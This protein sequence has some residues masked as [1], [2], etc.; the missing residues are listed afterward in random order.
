MLSSELNFV[1]KFHEVDAL[2]I[3]W[4]GHYI[5]YFEEG[6]EDFGARYGITYRDFMKEGYV[7]PVVEA[8][9]KYKKMLMYGDH[10]KMVSTFINNPAAKIIFQYTLYNPDTNEVIAEGSTVQVFLDNPQRQLQ[11]MPPEFFMSWKKSQGL[12]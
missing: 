7:A 3:V 6:R 5:R 1:V 4:H 12:Y 11:L 2:G 9:C 10:V 8:N